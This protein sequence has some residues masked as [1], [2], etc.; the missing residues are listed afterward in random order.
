MGGKPKKDLLEF[1]VALGDGDGAQVVEDVSIVLVLHRNAP[2]QSSF[3]EELALLFLF[4]L[5]LSMSVRCWGQ[6]VRAAFELSSHLAGEDDGVGGGGVPGETGQAGF[7][8]V[9][10]LAV[11]VDDQEWGVCRC[12]Q[13]LNLRAA[14][15]FHL[16]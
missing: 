5:F 4:E 11:V 16:I 7:G 15:F 13:G 8:L 3:R 10:A 9:A 1:G 6:E 12:R 14:L 2:F